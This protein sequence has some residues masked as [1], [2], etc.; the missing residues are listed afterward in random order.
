[1]AIQLAKFYAFH[2]IKELQDKMP[3]AAAHFAKELKETIVSL[4]QASGVLSDFT[5]MFTILEGAEMLF[6]P[7]PGQETFR[8][9][10]SFR[11]GNPEDTRAG[12]FGSGRNAFDVQSGH[13][14]YPLH[15]AIILIGTFAGLRMRR[16][17]AIASL[18]AIGHLFRIH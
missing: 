10:G 13:V 3:T 17:C 15:N 4:S 9:I 11:R 1:M 18:F 6:H 14:R 16:C 8:S 5:A 7:S 12:Y 2:N